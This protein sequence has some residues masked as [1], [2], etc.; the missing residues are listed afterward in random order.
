MQEEV[1]INKKEKFSTLIKIVLF[2]VL[3]FV[4]QLLS[5]ILIHMILKLFQIDLQQELTLPIVSVIFGQ[6]I[7]LI[8][9][10][11]LFN[12][13]VFKQLEPERK[14]LIT[15]SF[16]KGLFF[17]IAIIALVILIRGLF[18]TV[19][20]F[21]FYNIKTSVFLILGNLIIT[22]SAAVLEEYIFRFTLYGCFRKVFHSKR[23]PMALVSIIFSFMHFKD[24]VGLIDLLFYFM[25]SVFLCMILDRMKSLWWAIGFHTGWNYIADGGNIFKVLY[26]QE[27]QMQIITLKIILLIGIVVAI[28]ALYTYEK[29]VLG[30]KEKDGN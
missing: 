26:K 3:Y 9:Y 28:I 22:F 8:L 16:L 5:S 25:F 20:E 13:I 7:F 21:S 12:K 23:W 2:V 24:G 6:A 15:F 19:L 10:I 11:K 27:T 18:D 14:E 4:A 1:L 30:G 17:G 29:I